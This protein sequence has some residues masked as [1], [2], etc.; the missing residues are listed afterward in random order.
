[1][2]G[3]S[4][5]GIFAAGVDRETES[6]GLAMRIAEPDDDRHGV[7]PG[8]KHDRIRAT[9]T[10]DVDDESRKENECERERGH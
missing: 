4:A 3:Q 1:M 6:F 9:V 8:T 5:D 2:N 10:V 7:F